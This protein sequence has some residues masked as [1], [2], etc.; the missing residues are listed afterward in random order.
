MPLQHDGTGLFGVQLS[1]VL[2]PL[3]Q[4]QPFWQ[5]STA[6]PDGQSPMPEQIPPSS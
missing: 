2:P 5:V 6:P 1:L 4:Q 3:T